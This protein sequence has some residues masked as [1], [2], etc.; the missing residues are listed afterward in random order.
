MIHRPCGEANITS[1]C[2]ENGICTK[3]FPKEFAE[4]T[5]INKDGYPSYRR[6]KNGSC[7]IKGYNGTNA[8]V[9]PYNKYL[10]AKFNCH[11]NVE[12]CTSIKSVKYIFK[13]IYKGYD[14]AE[15]QI[16]D[17]N[18]IDQYI[19][20]RYVSAPEAMWRLMEYK[21]HDRSHK[22]NRLPVHLPREQMV[23]FKEGREEEA[24]RNSDLQQIQLLAWFKLNEEDPAARDYFYS[25][26]PLHY[27]YVKGVWK[28]RRNAYSKIIT[29]LYAV[30]PSYKE[31]FFLRLLLLNVKGAT[32]FEDLRTFNGVV[33]PSF[34]EAVE[35][36]RLL[37]NDNEWDRVL[38]EAANTQPPVSIRHLFGYIC[39]FNQLSSPLLLFEKYYEDM[40]EDFKEIDNAKD[41]LLSIIK[42]IVNSHG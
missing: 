13:Y 19:N 4:K 30:P 1:P 39:A 16:T 28:K 38:E 34:E 26:I 41:R 18:E 35:E 15:I 3:S 8:N 33:Y 9:V 37:I 32:S 6:S 31:R 24:V 22:I 27:T 23:V 7:N 40:I 5:K 10:L 21:M 29:R 2:M 25:E 36:R 14:C 17:N 20:S 11:I 42:D 12:V